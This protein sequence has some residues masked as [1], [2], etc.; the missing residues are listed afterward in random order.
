[1]R[2]LSIAVLFSLVSLVAALSERGHSHGNIHARRRCRAKT[3]GKQNRTDRVVHQTGGNQNHTD[4]NPQNQTAGIPPNHTA[5]IPPNH[6]AGIPPNHTA[7]IPPNHTAG[8]PPKQ[9]GGKY[10]LVDQYKGQDFIDEARVRGVA[11]PWA[12]SSVLI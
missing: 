10:Q 12:A 6:T 5:G 4:G 9:T 11:S 8:I 2:L 3:G 1:M 7:G